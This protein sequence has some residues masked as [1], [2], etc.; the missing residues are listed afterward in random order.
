MRTCV[1]VCFLSLVRIEG[2]N[3]QG[4]ILIYNG[5]KIL[6]LTINLSHTCYSCQSLADIQ[7]DIVNG[8]WLVILLKGAIF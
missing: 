3:I 7:S 2:Q 1:A 4:T 6:D 5:T 8:H